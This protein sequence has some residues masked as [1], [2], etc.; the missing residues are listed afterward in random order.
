MKNIK[1]CLIVLLLTLNIGCSNLPVP[2]YYIL[3]KFN[4]TVINREINVIIPV[5]ICE[6]VEGEILSIDAINNTLIYINDN[7]TNIT[8]VIIDVDTS[9]HPYVNLND[10]N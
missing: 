6:R 10:L 8:E 3:Y 7:Y 1:W 5:E 2:D 9:C 4:T